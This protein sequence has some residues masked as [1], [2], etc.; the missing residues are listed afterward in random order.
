MTSTPKSNT[1]R[2]ADYHQRKREQTPAERIRAALIRK[3][4]F[5]QPPGD[6]YTEAE[7][8]QVDLLK[9]YISEIHGI[10]DDLNRMLRER[11][12]R[13]NNDNPDRVMEAQALLAEIERHTNIQVKFH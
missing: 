4:A 5:T 9:S 10:T 7:Q 1:Q 12:L 2:Q 11:L 3:R 13:T 6:L 8:G